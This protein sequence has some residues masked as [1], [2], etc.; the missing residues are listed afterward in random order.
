[1]FDASFSGSEFLDGA[2]RA[3]PWLFFALLAWWVMFRAPLGRRVYRREISIRAPSDKIWSASFLEPSPPGGWG[4]VLHVIEQKFRDGAP[5]RHETAIKRD[6]RSGLTTMLVTRVT[7][8]EPCARFESEY[9]T[10]DGVAIAPADTVRYAMRLEEN[11]DETL[12]ALEISQPVRGVIG[13]LSTGRLHERHLD[14]L[15]AHC[16]GRPVWRPH[17]L[18]GRSSAAWLAVAAVA[19]SAALI[20]MR[21]PGL[22]WLCIVIAI[23]L[24]LSILVHEYGHFL[25]MRWFGH[26]DASMVLIPFFGGATF[27]MRGV[28]SRY[29]KAMIALAGPGISALAVLALTPLAH[30]G[31]DAMQSGARD[32][33]AL[34]GLGAAITLGI[35]VPMNLFNLAPVG[36]FDGGKLVDALAHGRSARW[37]IMSAIFAALGLSMTS[38]ESPSDFGVDIALIAAFWVYDLVTAERLDQPLTPMNREQLAMTLA[39]L[40]LMLMIYADASR[41][42]LPPI[43]AVAQDGFPA[44]AA[45][46]E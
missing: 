42:L 20:G 27:G 8:L 10:I 40:V 13:Y 9:E 29:E 30:W 1:M 44:D 25:A 5:L 26:H 16:E 38:W 23:C 35:A 34:V 32:V 14:H 36:M 3:L 46:S 33:K 17:S 6:A 18:V 21:N 43:M 19:A 2:A 4:G 31:I 39:A 24:E 7:R 12:V 28:S 37:L 15:R 45:E 22:G 41:R 11:G